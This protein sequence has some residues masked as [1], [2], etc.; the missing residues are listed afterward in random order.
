ME[1][2]CKG[3][4]SF[5]QALLASLKGQRS[6]LLAN[7]QKPLCDVVLRCGGIAT[8]AH[9]SVLASVSKYF[10]RILRS[11]SNSGTLLSLEV[12]KLF[13]GIESYFPTVID[14]FYTGVQVVSSQELTN[15]LLTALYTN[16]E[17][18]LPFAKPHVEVKASTVIPQ[19]VQI[20][21]ENAM[22]ISICP[23]CNML[24]VSEAEFL[25]HT[26]LK[27]ARK[28]ICYTCG[29]LFTRV[30]NLATH[31]TE[32]RHGETV[33]SICGFEGESQKDAELHIGKHILSN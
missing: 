31:L 10:E 7:G 20:Q 17:L 1:E 11:N 16:L 19:V 26:K 24:F 14:S 12:G 25:A 5:S 21:E 3:S 27:C 15:S 28:L 33:C 23:Q 30:Q 8:Q 32:V 9:S 29:K 18:Q 4:A 6:N 13:R 2:T 22:N